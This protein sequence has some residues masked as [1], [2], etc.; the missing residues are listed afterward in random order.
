MER[1][2]F[3][4]GWEFPPHHSGGLGVACQGMA[5]G[6]LA[7]DLPV[8]FVLPKS[9]PDGQV[10][11]QS[12][13]QLAPGLSMDLIQVNSN[14]EPYWQQ[15][16]DSPRADMISEAYRYGQV[17]GELAPRFDPA[18]LHA[19]DDQNWMN[20]LAD[21]SDLAANQRQQLRRHA[22]AD[23]GRAVVYRGQGGI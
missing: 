20:D 10:Y 16:A 17:V 3:M 19:H 13:H 5:R 9:I 12:K 11:A 15:T 22:A 21:S 18:V 4:I 2:I 23:F 8:A 1:P 7:L 14:L 6:L